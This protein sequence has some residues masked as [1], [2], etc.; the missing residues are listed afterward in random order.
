MVWLCHGGHKDPLRVSA[1]PFPTDLI[2]AVAFLR[3]AAVHHVIM[4]QI[5]VARA[6]PNLWVHDDRAI[7]AD[8]FVRTRGT[9][10]GQEFVM[11]LTHVL[12]P[13]ILDVPLE[14]DTERPIVPKAV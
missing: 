9:R 1:N 14:F 5:V 13:R 7:E 12:P 11:V 8:H 4:K 6:L 3:H 2:K 10:R